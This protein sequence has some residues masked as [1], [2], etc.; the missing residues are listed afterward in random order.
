MQIKGSWSLIVFY[1]TSP[2]F[3]MIF[4][5]PWQKLPDLLFH[6]SLVNFAIY[7]K[8]REEVRPLLSVYLGKH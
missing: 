3:L 7:I 2:I 1:L 5:L 6:V 8:V 4:F